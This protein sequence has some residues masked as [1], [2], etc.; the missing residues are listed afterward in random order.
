MIFRRMPQTKSVTFE[1][2]E[3][4]KVRV[5]DLLSGGYAIGQEEID[6]LTANTAMSNGF[7]QTLSDTKHAPTYVHIEI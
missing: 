6:A 5:K 2:R 1:P 7:G 3:N 4:M